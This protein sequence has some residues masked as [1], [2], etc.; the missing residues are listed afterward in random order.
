MPM[1][2]SMGMRALHSGRPNPAKWRK[3]MHV[4]Q[5]FLMRV[6]SKTVFA[7]FLVVG[8]GAGL[9]GSALVASAQDFIPA[10]AAFDNSPVCS[11][12]DLENNS[13]EARGNPEWKPVN[14]LTIDPLNPVLNDKPT[15]LEGFVPFP[16]ANE[17]SGAQAASEV[18][19][20]DLPWN[21]YTHDFTFQ[22]VPDARY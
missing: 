9:G 10:T 11:A 21:H 15:I 7:M 19:E 4:R 16:P 12:S 14:G 6:L 8:A 3:R 2:S 5:T 17:G 20:E 13:D 1:G 18:S 22:V